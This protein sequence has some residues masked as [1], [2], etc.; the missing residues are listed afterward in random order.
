MTSSRPTSRHTRRDIPPNSA[1]ADDA[2]MT[3]LRDPVAP[4]GGQGPTRAAAPALAASAHYT[5]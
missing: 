5:G 4:S 1:L 2:A 3:R